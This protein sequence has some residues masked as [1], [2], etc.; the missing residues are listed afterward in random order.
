M[1]HTHQLPPRIIDLQALALANVFEQRAL[2]A[3]S[4]PISLFHIAS[5]I[6]GKTFHRADLPFVASSLRNFAGVN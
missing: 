1:S 4:I 2:Q 5:C 3:K 6:V